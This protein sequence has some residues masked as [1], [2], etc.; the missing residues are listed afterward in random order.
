MTPNETPLRVYWRPGCPY[1]S[2]LRMAL[3]EAGVVASW[4]NI[5]EDPAA[6]AFVRSVAG[7]NETVPTVAYDGETLVAPRPRRLLHDLRRTHPELVTRAG[8]SWLPL[9]VLQWAGVVALVLVSEVLARSG[10]SALSWGVDG[11]AVAWFLAVRWFRMRP[12]RGR[13]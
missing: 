13:T 4:Q 6:A 11:V 5:Y 12:R 9:R 2:S 3:N 8:R 10:R 7:G 1:C